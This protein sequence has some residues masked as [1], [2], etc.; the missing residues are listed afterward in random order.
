MFL[1]EQLEALQFQLPEQVQI[2]IDS[3]YVLNIY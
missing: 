3:K 1:R 2:P